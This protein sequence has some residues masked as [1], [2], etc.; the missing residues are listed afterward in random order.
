MKEKI[1]KSEQKYLIRELQFSDF[2]SL[3]KMYDSLS[4][5][6]KLFFH[7]G[8]LGFRYI[9]FGWFIGQIELFFSTTN[10]IRKVL[11][12][13][14]PFLCFLPLVT[15][16]QKGEII[17]FAYLKI[18]KGLS[19]KKFQAELGIGI[20]DEYQG[21][22]LGSKL[23]EELITFGLEENV[24]KIRLTVLA[25]NERGI[26]L[27]EKYGFKR[28]RLIKNGEK[29]NGKAYDQIEMELSLS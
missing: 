29:W 8:F 24:K 12:S 13:I 5:E 11:L 25:H 6:S 21:L 15:I 19:S 22:G 26:R 28:K 1:E 9:S 27:Y 18:R 4:E 3:N 20:K 16:N 7:P 2:Y 14:M 23:M 10:P 17:G